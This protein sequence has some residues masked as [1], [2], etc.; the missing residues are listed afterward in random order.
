MKKQ[1]NLSW[2]K[3]VRCQEPTAL[4]GRGQKTWPE[5]GVPNEVENIASLKLNWLLTSHAIIWGNVVDQQI[6]KVFSGH[7][8]HLNSGWFGG[9][10]SATV[11]PPQTTRLRKLAGLH[12]KSTSTYFLKRWK[13]NYN[14]R[15]EFRW[16]FYFFRQ[17]WCGPMWG[18]WTL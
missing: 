9:H 1:F 14:G 17:V 8:N 3:P 16:N 5:V 10:A 15:K 11:S 18:W 7:L 2:G 13:S 6:F 12:L 4:P